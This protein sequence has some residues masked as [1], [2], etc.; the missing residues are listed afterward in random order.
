MYC[1]LYD[2]MPV[3]QGP[4]G[5]RKTACNL[6]V[7]IKMTN[8]ADDFN[9]LN[10]NNKMKK[11]RFNPTKPLV[12]RH[13]SHKSYAL[14]ACL[15]KV[16]IIGVLSVS[17]LKH[18]KADGISVRTELAD[19][20]LK[21]APIG[22]DEVTITGSRA[23]LTAA[24]AARMVTVVSR[25]EIE[26]AEANSISDILKQVTGVDVR[27]RGA[28]GIQTDIA[29][30]G[31]TFDQT[32]ILLNGMN[33]SSTQTGHNAT[34]FP[35]SISD[36]ERIEIIS[37]P[38]A[39]LMGASA[40]AG[41]INIVT[42]RPKTSGI[43]LRAEGGSFG[44]A[45]TEA[46]MALSKGA[47]KTMIATG[48]GQSDGGT[49]NSDFHMRRAYWQGSISK[50][51]L[52]LRWQAGISSRD[53]GASTF[54][55]ARFNNQY[56]TTRRIIASVGA[57][58]AIP[59][60]RILISP[61]LYAHR[62]IDHYQLTRG[63]TG[64]E[65]GEN[66]HRTDNYGLQLNASTAWTLGRTTI[67]FDIARDHIL[68][69]A[70]GL[71]MDESKWK[72][73]R[74]S[75]RKYNRKAGRT[76]SSITLE[77]NI[78][79]QQLSLSVGMTAI[80]NT[81]LDSSIRFYQGIDAAY[82]PTAEWKI[83][84]SVNKGLRLPTFTDL[85][86]AN[87]IQKGDDSLRPERNTMMRI[88]AQTDNPISNASLSMFYS[89]GRDMIDWVYPDETSKQYHAM[90]IGRLNNLGI[91]ADVTL[92]MGKIWQQGFLKN[93][94]L[95]YSYIH[96]RHS[97]GQPIWK[98]LYALEYLRH[99]FTAQVDH[100]IWRNLSATW[101]FRWQQRMNGYHPYAKIDCRI[102][103]NT[104]KYSLWMKG[105]NLTAHR[106]YDLGGVRQP[107]LWIMAGA[108]VKLGKK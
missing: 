97:T 34:D 68:S 22:L 85:Y 95:S 105:D 89:R 2:A 87:A 26:R 20:S 40:F 92:K 36:I 35:V 75:S 47:L 65:N 37:G 104:D 77:H 38:A 54:Y 27:Q 81:G 82:R 67:G 80:R 71:P 3:Y 14:F 72:D 8:F 49:E 44:T 101:A 91:D 106:Y 58:V 86:I 56:E 55:T 70:Y 33:L 94:R 74:N 23:P 28:F 17:T 48:Y 12:F 46:T 52:L 41:A 7:S 5:S 61:T 32:A 1:S 6:A 29:T 18:A 98:S 4:N 78:V 43:S 25:D 59:G 99:K 10:S 19:D 15:G 73:I 63:L 45:S 31:G 21:R 42:R 13:F 84:A 107:G 9:T 62:D 39:R 16:V 88:G 11:Q 90:N 83:F 60:T 93:I 24:E 53:F 50:T 64:A 103:W 51:N 66:L 108:E 100:H 57:D 96:Q 79:M 69:T 102:A 76:N 30:S